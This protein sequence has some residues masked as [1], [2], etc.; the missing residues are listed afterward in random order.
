MRISNTIT[1]NNF[2]FPEMTPAL[3]DKVVA[4]GQAIIDVR[5]KFPNNTLAELYESS[6]MPPELAKAHTKLD[7]DVLMAYGLT[8]DADDAEILEVLFSMYAEQS[9]NAQSIR[10][11]EKP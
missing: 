1:Y 4:S 11:K 2:P 9:R 8:A 6:S 7:T 10:T 5:R 3:R